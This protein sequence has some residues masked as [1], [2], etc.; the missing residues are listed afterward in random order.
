MPG[1][2][3]VDGELSIDS[4]DGFADDDGEIF[5]GPDKTRKD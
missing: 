3:G 4:N 1:V 5:V 2:F